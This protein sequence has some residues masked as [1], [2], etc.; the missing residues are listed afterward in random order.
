MKDVSIIT[1]NY[2]SSECTIALV[3]SIHKNTKLNYEIIIVDNCS[4]NDDYIKLDKI[5]SKNTTIIRSDVNLGFS[6]GNMLAIPHASGKHL[7]FINN[8]TILINSA[9]DI[10]HNS[11][12]SRENTNIAMMSPQIYGDGGRMSTSFGYFPTIREKLFGKAFRNFFSIKKTFNNRKKYNNV[13]EVEV[14][15]G[16]SMF[17]RKEVFNSIGGF[18]TNFF[19][20][21]EEEDLSKRLWDSGFKICLEPS[22]KI[23]HIE[24]GSTNRNFYIEREFI[25]S[26]FYLLDKH[27][28]RLRALVLKTLFSFKYWSKA[29]KSS[30][31]KALAKFCLARDKRRYSLRFHKE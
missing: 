15:S 14:I 24:G 16:A 5:R 28:G 19:L 11:M 17:I 12:I 22:A 7:F 10:L 21:C 20:Y 26:Y 3:D 8:D 13:I 18:D 25:I 1:I 31:K 6:G 2:N 4:H 30:D 29:I 27:F 23:I 9:I